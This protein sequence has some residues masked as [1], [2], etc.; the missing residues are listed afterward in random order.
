QGAVGFGIVFF[1]SAIYTVNALVR[2]IRGHARWLP[3][4]PVANTRTGQ[5]ALLVLSS[6][7]SLFTF[8]CLLLAL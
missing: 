7:I 6:S 1:V 5:V 3:S 8:V 4:E 2:L